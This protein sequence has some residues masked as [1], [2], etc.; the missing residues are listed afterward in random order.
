MIYRFLDFEL[1]EE[2]FEIRMDGSP[3]LTQRKAFDFVRYLLLNRDR[4]VSHD[5]LGDAVWEGAAR[6]L[7]TI[8]QCAASVRRALGGDTNPQAVIQTV[9]GRGYRFVAAV[10]STGP[11]VGT[12]AVEKPRGASASAPHFVG[13]HE[14]MAALRAALRESLS[15]QTRVVLLAGEPGIGK[16]RV[17]EELCREATGSGAAAVTGR[18]YEGE[19]APA[20]WPWIQAVRDWLRLNNSEPIPGELEAEAA[21]FASWPPEVAEQSADPATRGRE[22]AE[23]RFELFDT[24]T[25]GFSKLAARMPLVLVLEDLHW[26]DPGSLEFMRFLATQL[27]H[28]P[29]LILGTYRE[30]ELYGTPE[31]AQTLGDLGRDPTFRRLLVDGLEREHVAE[32]LSKIV[33]KDIT[34]ALAESV[35]ALTEGNPFFVVELARILDTEGDGVVSGGVA[36]G[37]EIELPASISDAIGCRLGRL[38]ADS[39]KLLSVASVIG[40]EFGTTLLSEVAG[41]EYELVLELLEE[42]AAI[43]IIEP[44]RGSADAYRFGHALIHETLYQGTLG[45]RRARLHGVVA[46]AL[47]RIQGNSATPPVAVLAHHWYQAVATGNVEKAAEYCERAGLLALAGLAFEEAAG[48]LKRALNLADLRPSPDETGRCELML[49]LGQA[50]WSAGEHQSAHTTFARAAA[51]ARRIGSVEHFA[52]AAIGYYG[53]EHGASADATARALLE[54]A[55]AGL[56]EGSPRLR[57]GVL[58]KLQLVTPYIH[59]NEMRQSMSLEALELARRSG[60]IEAL[61]GAFLRREHATVSPEYFCERAGWAKECRELGEKLGDPWLSW[62]GNDFVLPL[63]HGHRDEM[64]EALRESTRYSALSGDRLSQF[65]TILSQ[66]SFA[67][68]EGRFNEVQGLVAQIP[69]AG[70]NCVAWAIEAFSGYRFVDA[71][72]RGNVDRL[73]RE[74][75]PFFEAMTASF[76]S[77]H[78]IG[79]SSIALI[80]TFS[81]EWDEALSELDWLLGIIGPDFGERSKN[82][83]WIYAMHMVAEVIELLDTQ[84]HAG[85]LAPELEPFA[86]LMACHASFRWTGGSVA[87]MRGLLSSVLGDFEAGMTQFEAGMK[88]EREL[89]AKPAVLRSKAGL[90]RLFLRRRMKGD[91][92]RAMALMEQVVKGCEELGI[93]PHLKYVVPFERLSQ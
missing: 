93:N 21:L 4:V 8:P 70:K 65:F 58:A 80:R 10:D 92:S 48:H 86:D 38:S 30:N 17:V 43:G 37:L 82:E 15:G 24:A 28:A 31:L 63:L 56:G 32:L 85:I 54:E 39:R 71:V 34:S 51:L 25:R 26:A 42:A 49:H 44:V 64:L 41:P 53:F 88:M 62:L 29:L 18:C 81:E 20:F 77:R 60:D 1:D 84:S 16:T 68:M 66:S 45:P 22:G 46:Q 13:R 47:E 9:H 76:E 14:L 90:A 74:W 75:L 61:R 50:Q 23:A 7:S 2:S 12:S 33:R 40:R 19:G 52:K 59:S 57:S 83:N 27:H 67:L 55:A 72:E 73:N 78:T 91:Q 87:T 89:G 3:A 36:E 69:E 79:H 5:E 6:S 35:A 11:S